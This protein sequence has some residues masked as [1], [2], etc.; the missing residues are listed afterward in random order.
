MVLRLSESSSEHRPSLL[1]SLS[2]LRLGFRPRIEDEHS[3]SGQWT[4]PPV[5]GSKPRSP[6]RA[7]F[8]DHPGGALAPS[9][10]QCLRD[11]PHSSESRPQ[12]S[13]AEHHRRARRRDDHISAA[14]LSLPDDSFSTGYCRDAAVAPSNG[15][16]FS[17]CPAPCLRGTVSSSSLERTRPC[18]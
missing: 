9:E 8:R 4:C 16:V 7:R 1:Q 3:A 15:R 10:T 11:P 2:R 12:S 13:G 14:R 6:P 18:R 5:P 17:I